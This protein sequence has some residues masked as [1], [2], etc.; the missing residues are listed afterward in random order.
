MTNGTRM[1]MN[2]KCCKML[3]INACLKY[4]SRTSLLSWPL[5][6]HCTKQRHVPM[7]W[8]IPMHSADIGQWNRI[9]RTFSTN[10]LDDDGNHARQWPLS[11]PN[12]HKSDWLL[13]WVFSELVD[14]VFLL[15][16]H[17]LLIYLQ[18]QHYQ[19]YDG[20]IACMANDSLCVSVKWFRVEN[21]SLGHNDAIINYSNEI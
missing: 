11:L 20:C 8:K 1:E 3:H 9:W 2:H 12:I 19:I 21:C 6:K 14:I 5:W 10:D 7:R 4:W 18:F 15:Q 16:P 13:C 17:G